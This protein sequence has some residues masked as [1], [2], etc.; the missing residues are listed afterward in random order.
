MQLIFCVKHRTTLFGKGERQKLNTVST[1][2][3]GYEKDVIKN[4]DLRNN[5]NK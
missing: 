1:L 5:I 4:V 2:C 3:N